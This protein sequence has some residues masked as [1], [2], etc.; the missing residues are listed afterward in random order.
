[1]TPGPV[2]AGDFRETHLLS[3]TID[4][5]PAEEIVRVTAAGELTLDALATLIPEGLA[6]T[7]RRGVRR[8]LVDYR[9]VVPAMGTMDIYQAPDA[10]LRSGLTR[11]PRVAFVMPADPQD[12]ADF[13]FYEDRAALTGLS[14]RVLCQALT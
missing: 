8:T 10:A 2:A 12:R 1:M 3:W 11:D 14:N 13:R 9:T 4:Y 7:A 6:E 5:L